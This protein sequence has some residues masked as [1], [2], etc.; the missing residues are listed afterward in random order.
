MSQCTWSGRNRLIKQNHLSRAAARAHLA[1]ST[2]ALIG[3]FGGSAQAVTGTSTWLS[4]SGTNDWGTAS[5][6]T[7]AVVPSNATNTY[8]AK[9]DST[10]YAFNPNINASF[11]VS[12]LLFGDGTTAT[13]PVTISGSAGTDVLT[14]VADTGITVPVVTTKT[15]GNAPTFIYMYNNSGAVTIS[16][17]TPATMRLR[18]SRSTCCRS[19]VTLPCSTASSR[20]GPGIYRSE[21][22]SAAGSRWMPVVRAP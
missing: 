17:R 19:P 22:S 10:S 14:L 8:D 12:D 3:I 18:I 16:A 15:N 20:A 6:W 4:S 5:N 7:P 9:F 13:A 1:L 11:T 21:V 2:A